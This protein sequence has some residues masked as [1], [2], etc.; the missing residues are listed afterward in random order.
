MSGLIVSSFDCS[1]CGEVVGVHWF[2]RVVFFV[3]ILLVTVPSA[4]A[5]L[6]Q[7][8]VY[9]ALLWAPFPIGAIGYIKARICPLEVK[10]HRDDSRRPSPG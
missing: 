4:V 2:Y 5:V 9:A 6:A 1:N 3:V 10:R 8:G 7:Q